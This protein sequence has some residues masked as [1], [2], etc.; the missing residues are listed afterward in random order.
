MNK[1]TEVPVGNKSM[2]LSLRG[3]IFRTERSILA[4]LLRQGGG[5]SSR[6]PASPRP[7]QRRAACG[8]CP[9]QRLSTQPGQCRHHLLEQRDRR[10]GRR[11]GGDE[12]D[13]GK[14]EK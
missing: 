9:W 3:L 6:L 4:S 13:Y 7:V 2:L 11:K 14:E 5:C 8:L 10:E 1:K 12:E